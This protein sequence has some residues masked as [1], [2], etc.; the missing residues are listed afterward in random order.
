MELLLDLNITAVSTL[1]LLYWSRYAFL[2]V[3]AHTQVD[4]DHLYILLDRDYAIITGLLRIVPTPAG[5]N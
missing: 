1:L 3:L 2:L 5:P 4:F